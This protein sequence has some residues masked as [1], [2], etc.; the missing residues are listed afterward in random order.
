MSCSYAVDWTI[1]VVVD[2]R[3]VIVVVV[4]SRDPFVVETASVS[5][6]GS[7]LA[8][9]VEAR[10][11]FVGDTEGASDVGSKVAAVVDTIG[12]SDVV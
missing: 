10:D 6:V 1:T 2:L 12:P 11:S 8:S 3:V 9:V 7:R 5:D 4:D